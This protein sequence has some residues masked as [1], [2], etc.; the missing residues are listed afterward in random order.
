MDADDHTNEAGHE[1]NDVANPGPNDEA[2]IADE[3]P[4]DV[5]GGPAP[6]PQVAQPLK[7][8]RSPGSSVRNP[9]DLT[10]GRQICVD[11][12]MCELIDLSQDK[13]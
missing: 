11:G 6:P 5:G 2:I 12:K 4:P 1:H 8:G 10:S 13:A 3:I 7:R 9:I